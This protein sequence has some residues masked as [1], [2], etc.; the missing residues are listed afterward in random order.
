MNELKDAFLSL[1]INKSLRYDDVSLNVLKKYFK[2][3]LET[4]KYLFT[5]S[6]ENGIFSDDLKIAKVTPI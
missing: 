1:K 4:L 6:I 2:S 5:L 3:L